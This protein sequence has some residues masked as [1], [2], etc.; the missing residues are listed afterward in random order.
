MIGRAQGGV[1]GEVTGLPASINP[2]CSGTWTA[3]SRCAAADLADYAE[4]LRLLERRHILRATYHNVQSAALNRSAL[5]E[6]WVGPLH[7]RRLL[8]TDGLRCGLQR[9]CPGF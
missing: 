5:T 3:I 6:I 9:G 7:G 2:C 1:A 8:M 4:E